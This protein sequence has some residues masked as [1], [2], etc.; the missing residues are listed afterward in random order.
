MLKS[1]GKSMEIYLYDVRIFIF[2]SCVF[3]IQNA[4]IKTVNANF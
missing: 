3:R 2:D 4:G 1:R